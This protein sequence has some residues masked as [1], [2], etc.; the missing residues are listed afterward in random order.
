MPKT[1]AKRGAGKRAN[2]R[3]PNVIAPVARAIANSGPRFSSSPSGLVVRHKEYMNTMAC[4]TT[5]PNNLIVWTCQPGLKDSFPWL[6]GISSNFDRYHFRRLR[7]CFEG[8]AASTVSGAC[9]MSFEPD[10]S[11]SQPDTIAE[12]MQ[13]RMAMQGS[14][15]QGCS[16]SVP[17]QDLDRFVHS[18]YVRVEDVTDDVKTYDLGKFYAICIGLAG[19]TNVGDM[20]V[21]YE[22]ELSEPQYSIMGAVGTWKYDY[23]TCAGQTDYPPFPGI[24][25]YT[26]VLTNGDYVYQTTQ[27]KIA[28]NSA[29]QITMQ[30]PG[31]YIVELRNWVYTAVY[32][33]SGNL[34]LDASSTCVATNVESS[35]V[36]DNSGSPKTGSGWW[37]GQVYV[38]Y[39]NATLVFTGGILGTAGTTTSTASITIAPD[40]A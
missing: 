12:L 4:V 39:R 5:Y 37:V 10:A 24:T 28:G 16:L 13:N 35:W 8:T 21:E 22:V 2:T 31:Y 20:Y 19:V 1:N 25:G 34:V 17:C 38:P 23:G 27:I 18:R 11:Q 3:R 14:L 9:Y 30:E 6:S 7:Y 40:S 26:P 29:T 36:L 15:W 33:G 32:A